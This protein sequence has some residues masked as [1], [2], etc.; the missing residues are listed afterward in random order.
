MKL[1]PN[2]KKAILLAVILLTVFG[3][4]MKIVLHYTPLVT[5]NSP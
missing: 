5:V 3:I 1:T 2:E 4:I